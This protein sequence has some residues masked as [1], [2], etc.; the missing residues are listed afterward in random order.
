[1]TR[2]APDPTIVAMLMAARRFAWILAACVITIAPGL[3]QDLEPRRWTHLPV[4]TD[5]IALSYAFGTG[6]LSFDPVLRIEE[7][8][9]DMS[10]F[11]VG[12]T[13]YFAL[14]RRTARIDVLVPFQ[15]G[16]WD[17]LLDGMPRAVSRD[18]FA[19]PLVRLSVNLVGAPALSGAEFADYRKLHPVQTSVGAALELRLPL[20]E[21]QEDKLIN[22][23]QNR[24]GIAPQL[25]VLH[26]R[27]EWSYELTGSMYVFTDNDE[28]FGG[29]ELEQDP[30]F[31]TQAHVVKTFGPAWWFSLGAAYNWAG[32]STINGLSKGDDRSTLLYGPSFGFRLG[33]SQSVRAAYV[34]NDTLTDVGADTHNFAVGWSVR[35]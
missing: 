1:L 9:V 24:F 31:L 21:Y 28:F 34:R 18:G 10:T 14:A 7:A 5:V 23:G 22:L 33:D 19:D 29:N 12:Y 32:E 3:A 16:D 4:G 30:L 11:V 25:G 8:K 15:S 27:G 17:G 35:F 20:G 2:H 26:T 6:D 13:R